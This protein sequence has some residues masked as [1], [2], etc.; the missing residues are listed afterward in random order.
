MR[1]QGV[2][3]DIGPLEFM[4]MQAGEFVGDFEIIGPGKGEVGQGKGTAEVTGR[5]SRLTLPG[6]PMWAQ[7]KCCSAGRVLRSHSVDRI[8]CLRWGWSSAVSP[9]SSKT[10]VSNI[11]PKAAS[12][13]MGWGSGKRLGSCKRSIG[14]QRRKAVGCRG[15]VGQGIECL[16]DLIGRIKGC[17]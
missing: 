3:P 11:Q 7:A 2:G 4:F 13:R 8:W 12:L 9:R 15:G 5:Q 6:R 16:Q 10:R 14:D 17:A 1:G